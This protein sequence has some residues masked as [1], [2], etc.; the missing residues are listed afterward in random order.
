VA[1]RHIRVVADQDA[2]RRAALPLVRRNAGFEITPCRSP[3]PSA[4]T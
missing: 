4:F 3:M 2:H 1:V